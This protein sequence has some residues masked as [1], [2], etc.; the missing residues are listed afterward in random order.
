LIGD[1]TAGQVSRVHW[2]SSGSSARIAAV[3]PQRWEP[4]GFTLSHSRGP[5]T[6]ELAPKMQGI[7]NDVHCAPPGLWRERW[8]VSR[9]PAP[10]RSVPVITSIWCL[11]RHSPERGQ[12]ET[13]HGRPLA[14]NHLCSAPS[15]ADRN[16]CPPLRLRLHDMTQLVVIQPAGLEDAP[17]MRRKSRNKQADAI[18]S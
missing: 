12:R 15:I 5:T 11:E 14:M 7:M 10:V 8:N 13:A 3:C 2:R 4:L 18:R 6:F 16:I 17:E 9:S 1:I